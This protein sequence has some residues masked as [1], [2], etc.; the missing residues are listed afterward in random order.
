[1]QWQPLLK[2]NDV[3]VFGNL[4]TFFTTIGLKINVNIQ[5]QLTLNKK[6]K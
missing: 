2:G 3:Q 6:K 1:M 4:V 5:V